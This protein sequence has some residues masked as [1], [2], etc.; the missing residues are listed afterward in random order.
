M[1]LISNF[2]VKN[3]N[4]LFYSTLCIAIILIA[5]IPK[6]ELNDQFVEYFDE[7][8]EFRQSAEF[9]LE[10]LTGIYRAEWSIP[11]GNP[12]GITDPNYLNKLES[13]V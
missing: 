11:S 9:A 12:N 5:M 3:T 4:K 10:N 1:E 8:L 7:S 6:I 2:I 13:F